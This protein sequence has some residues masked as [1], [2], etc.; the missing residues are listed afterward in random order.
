MPLDLNRAWAD[1]LVNVAISFFASSGYLVLG[2][3]PAALV[4]APARALPIQRS[5]WSSYSV[6]L[7]S[8]ELFLITHE[9]NRSRQIV[10]SHQ[11]IRLHGIRE[12][13]V[14]DRQPDGPH[15]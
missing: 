4:P 12:M 6:L 11:H 3:T 10:R 8:S 2:P 13:V 14:A 15:R 1:G 9:S 7:K 5:K